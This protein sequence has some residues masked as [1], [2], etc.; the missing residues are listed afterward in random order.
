MLGPRFTEP[1]PAATRAAQAAQ[2][3][4][5]SVTLSDA[6][7]SAF[8]GRFYAPE[9]DATYTLN[10]VAHRL[11]LARPRA[12]ADTLRATD[13]HTFRG[14]GLTITFSGTN[15]FTVDNGRARGLEFTRAQ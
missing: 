10:A 5:A 3:A 15:A 6:A 9:L 4:S 1:V 13:E 7:L 12:P 2:Q 8:A 14:T 11:V